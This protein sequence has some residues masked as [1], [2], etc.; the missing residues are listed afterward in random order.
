MNRAVRTSLLFIA[1]V[2]SAL[3]A[4]HDDAPSATPANAELAP[5]ASPPM[6]ATMLQPT[7][8]PTASEP[9]YGPQSLMIPGG[10]VLPPDLSDLDDGQLVGIVQALHQADIEHLQLALRQS[11]SPAVQRFARDAIVMHRAAASQEDADLPE[12]KVTPSTSSSSQQVLSDWS[13]DG[14]SLRA[15]SPADFDLRFV[16]HHVL[17]DARA[18]ALLDAAI[19]SAR[20]ATVRDHLKGDRVSFAGHLREAQLLEQSVRSRA[21]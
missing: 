16:N 20:S 21:P 17:L 13:R 6:G 8:T 18:V 15:G 2:V 4:C 14:V 12:L 11:S 7:S 5:T 1:T 19:V 3:A 10:G 9:A